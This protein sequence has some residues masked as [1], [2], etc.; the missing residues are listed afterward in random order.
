MLG[1]VTLRL[2]SYQISEALQDF[3]VEL[4]EKA[5]SQR[6]TKLH[7][8][9]GSRG[10]QGELLQQDVAGSAQR[11]VV[12]RPE[13]DIRTSNTPTVNLADRVIVLVNITGRS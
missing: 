12:P 4:E 10:R 3:Q 7:L 1:R 5:E 11:L 13:D 8:S 6:A 9:P 2:K